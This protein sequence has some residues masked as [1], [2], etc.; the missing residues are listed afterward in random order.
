MT[1]TPSQNSSSR[2]DGRLAGA[3]PLARVP[4]F[5]DSWFAVHATTTTSINLMGRSNKWTGDL[6]KAERKRVK[7][8]RASLNGGVLEEGVKIDRWHPHEPAAW[9]ATKRRTALDSRRP[10]KSNS[11]IL[12]AILFCVLVVIVGAWALGY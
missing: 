4:W 8:G 12:H 7:T 1:Q 5:S 10:A 11:S 6:T 2:R 3:P 9:N